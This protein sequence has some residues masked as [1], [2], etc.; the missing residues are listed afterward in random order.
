MELR[1]C[2]HYGLPAVNAGR[3]EI[4]MRLVR[5]RHLNGWIYEML[6]DESD[7]KAQFG[8]DNQCYSLTDSSLGTWMNPRE[9][10]LYIKIP[11]VRVL[12]A[13]AGFEYEVKG[14]IRFSGVTDSFELPP[15]RIRYNPAMDR[16][17]CRSA[18]IFEEG[19]GG[20]RLGN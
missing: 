15:F 20:A 9:G 5:R 4:S 13:S 2:T 6:G 3:V 7:L 1:V 11:R 14:T 18:W 10:D 8:D 16:P 17:T 19:V 12:G